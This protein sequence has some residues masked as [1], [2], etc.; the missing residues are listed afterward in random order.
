MQSV[1][2]SE[3]GC[4]AAFAVAITVSEIRISVKNLVYKEGEIFKIDP[5]FEKILIRD[6][7]Q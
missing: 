6:K 3:H 7:L 2:E 1:A 4:S 5:L